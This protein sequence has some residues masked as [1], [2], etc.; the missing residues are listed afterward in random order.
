MDE[1]TITQEDGNALIAQAQSD[2]IS[3][4]QRRVNSDRSA[5]AQE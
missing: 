1:G 5:A 4:Y 3:E 2:A